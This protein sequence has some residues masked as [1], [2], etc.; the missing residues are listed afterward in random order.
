M[1]VWFDSGASHS[2][3]LEVYD[4]LYKPA[5][6]YLEGSDQ[7]RGWFQ[8]SL[9]TAVGAD[10][11]APYKSL[12]THGF[13]N[14]GKGMKMSKSAGNVVN[15]SEVIETYGADILRL[16][17]ASVDYREDVKI[18][19]GILKQMTESYRRLRNTARYILGNIND[20]DP[21]KDRVEYENL[22]EIDKWAMHKL[23]KL[24]RKVN[25]NY[26]KFEFY[27]LFYD[28]H[29]FAAVEMSAFYLDILKDRLYTTK[30]NSVE[31]RAAQTVMTDILI[32]FTKMMAPVLSFT[33]EEIWQMLPK[34]VK[35]S[36]SVLLSNWYEENDM[37]VNEELSKKWDKIIKL[38][39]NVNKNLEE[40]RKDKVIGHSLN[41]LVKIITNTNEEYEFINSNLSLLKDVFIASKLVVEKDESLDEAQIIIEK[42]PGEKCE[43]CWKYS[44]ELGKNEQY[45]DIC[46]S[47]TDALM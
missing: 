19:D 45:K 37:Y 17:C 10:G 41:A 13:V 15:P 36:E 44:E 5:D 27:N 25:E 6:M 47:C 21:A 33:S 40:A 42:A 7:H 29:Y 4:E 22:L 30:A 28:I 20:F 9:L 35:E 16:W 46:P 32:T 14:D 3:V 43:R 38:R 26:E 18:S 11:E 31:R 8:T 23:E 12:L 24:K 39:E 2:S 34:V 1:D